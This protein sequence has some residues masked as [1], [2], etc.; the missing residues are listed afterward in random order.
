CKLWHFA[1]ISVLAGLGEELLFRALLQSALID[2]LGVWPGILVAGLLFG[3][4][5]PLS[6]TYIVVAAAIG[7][8]LGWLFAA[9]SNL[10]VPIIAHALYDFIALV[11]LSR[12]K[13]VGQG[14]P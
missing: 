7:I 4:A 11:Y 10:L 2:W 14:V 5:H 1:V 3:L 6:R 9:T 12:T 13:R 8:Y